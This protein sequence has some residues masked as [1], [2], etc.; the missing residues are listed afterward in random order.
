MP[1][2]YLASY[3]CVFKSISITLCNF[4]EESLSNYQ[5][6][7][8]LN[9]VLV[10]VSCFQVEN[11]LGR[12]PWKCNFSITLIIRF[13]LQWITFCNSFLIH[14]LFLLIELPIYTEKLKFRSQVN[15]ILGKWFLNV[16]TE[17]LLS[18]AFKMELKCYLFNSFRVLLEFIKLCF[19]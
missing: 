5:V 16:W 10:W 15:I 6:S 13:M 1:V 18:L 12:L 4:W 9:L 7:R 8:L 2:N 11:T 19:I 3:F 14:S 17:K